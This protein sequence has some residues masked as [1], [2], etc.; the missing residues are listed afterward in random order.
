MLGIPKA[1]SLLKIC[2]WVPNVGKQQYIGVETY[3]ELP[4][5]TLKYTAKRDKHRFSDPADLF[6]FNRYKDETCLNQ[7]LS[8]RRTF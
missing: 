2:G 4:T 1:G 8:S 6:Q 7:F 5:P 3:V